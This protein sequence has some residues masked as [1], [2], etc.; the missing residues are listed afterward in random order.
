[1]EPVHGVI[2]TSFVTPLAASGLKT[3]LLGMNS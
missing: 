3:F 2:Y 1:M